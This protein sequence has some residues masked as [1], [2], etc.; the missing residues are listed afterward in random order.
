MVPHVEKELFALMEHE[1]TAG[2]QWG[3]CCLIFGFLCS[4]WQI[5]VCPSVLFILT[6]VLFVLIRLMVSDC[7]V[8]IFKC[9]VLGFS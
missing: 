6:I 3:S 9:F 2:F 1:S 8:G 4:V 7:P 5:K